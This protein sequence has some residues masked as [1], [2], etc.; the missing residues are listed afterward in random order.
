MSRGDQLKQS[1]KSIRKSHISATRDNDMSFKV[2]KYD[3][4]I[5]P[6]RIDEIPEKGQKSQTYF[7]KHICPRKEIQDPPRSRWAE[8]DFNEDL[9]NLME[10]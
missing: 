9:A 1:S 5:N 3:R 10:Y 8:Y 4:P 6:V 2:H 7:T